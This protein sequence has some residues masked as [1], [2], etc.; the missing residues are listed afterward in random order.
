MP[1]LDAK[2]FDNKTTTSELYLYFKNPSPITYME[3][4]E[5]TPNDK[6]KENV[7]HVC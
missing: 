1:S 5:S 7:D 4:F 6:G 2:S 3:T